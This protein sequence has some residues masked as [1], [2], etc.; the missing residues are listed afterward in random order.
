MQNALLEHLKTGSTTLCRAWLVRRKDGVTLGFTDHDCDLVFDGV[1]YTAKSG[2]TAGALEK[3]T[4]LAVDNTEVTGALSD[5]SVREED[6]LAGRYDGAEVTTFLVNWANVSE[7]SVLFRGSFGEITRSQG[8]FRVELR[9]LSESLNVKRGRIYH[10]ACGAVLGDRNCKVDLSTPQMSVVAPLVASR[11]G[12]T[13]VFSILPAFE[14]G[15][16]ADGYV[17]IETGSGQGQVGRI[18]VDRLA[19]QERRI[20][21]WHAF[22]VP[23]AAGDQMSLV[24][25]C[26]RRA[27]TCQSK[28]DNFLNF[29]GFPHIPGEDWLRS[30]PSRQ[31]RR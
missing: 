27:S 9:G 1:A 16:F 2:L 30:N 6:I 7:R 24:A 17:T 4:G 3:T 29:R 8:A 31:G 11:D 13:L 12:R 5:A 19:A 15:W 10:A 23:P 26:D 22:A 25:G 20:E 21:L 18:K 14:E 28:F